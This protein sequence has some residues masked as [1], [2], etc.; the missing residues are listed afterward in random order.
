[1][2]HSTRQLDERGDPQE[3][4]EQAQRKFDTA[5]RRRPTASAACWWVMPNSLMRRFQALPPSSSGLKISLL[6]DR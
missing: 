1:M 5:A 6:D 2:T 4:L 3:R